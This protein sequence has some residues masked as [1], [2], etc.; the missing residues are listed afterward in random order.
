MG[1]SVWFGAGLAVRSMAGRCSAATM[2]KPAQKIKYG[3]E[4]KPLR[5]AK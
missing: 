1:V 5:T 3:F 4:N 2:D